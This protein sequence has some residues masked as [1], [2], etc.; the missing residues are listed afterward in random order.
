MT[1]AQASAARQQHGLT[2]RFTATVGYIGHIQE[3]LDS[4][5]MADIACKLTERAVAAIEAAK[6]PPPVQTPRG[7]LESRVAERYL[8][9]AFS[10]A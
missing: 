4:R 10:A 3:P 8:F 6:V 1:P 9:S 2:I 7:T 5:S